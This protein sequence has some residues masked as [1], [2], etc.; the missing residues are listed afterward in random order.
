MIVVSFSKLGIS[1]KCV[2]SS[3]EIANI[4]H[5]KKMLILVQFKDSKMP[6]N[7]LKLPHSLLVRPVKFNRSDWSV[8]RLSS[9]IHPINNK[10]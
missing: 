6:S 2:Q 10:K 3:P 8:L 7:I 5:L 1:N 9:C 4:L